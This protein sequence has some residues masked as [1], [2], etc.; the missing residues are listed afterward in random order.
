MSLRRGFV[1]RDEKEMEFVCIMG[2]GDILTA[3]LAFFGGRKMG[4]AIL[5][6]DV[7]EF[8]AR[9]INFWV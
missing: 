5:V 9:Y 4:G 8:G 6:S 7:D 2:S 3:G 1:R